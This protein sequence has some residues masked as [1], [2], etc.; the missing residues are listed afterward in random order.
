MPAMER[1]YCQGPKC[2]EY[3]KPVDAWKTDIHGGLLY[4]R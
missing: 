3:G 2:N 1:Q 4:S